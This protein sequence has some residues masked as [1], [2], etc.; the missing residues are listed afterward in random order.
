[1]LARERRDDGAVTRNG[2]GVRG[3]GLAACA[4][5]VAACAAQSVAPEAT[6]V[7]E[8]ARKDAAAF[9]RGTV[10]DVYRSLRRGRLDSSQSLLADEAFVVGP[11]AVDVYTG[12]TDAVLA[13][14]NAFAAGD[15]HKLRS[16]GLVAEAS[17]TGQSAWVLDRIEI[18]RRPYTVVAVLAQV[19]DIWYVVAVHLAAAKPSAVEGELP[20]LAGGVGAGAEPVVEL[21]RAAVGGPD[22]VIEQLSDHARATAFGPGHKDHLR[23]K[24]KIART[25]KRKRR[26]PAPL[27]VTGN[28]RA[29]V[30]PDGGLAWVVANT[31]PADDKAGA[32]RRAMLVYERVEDQWRLVAM[33]T[34][35]AFR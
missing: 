34:A 4:L 30:T 24:R 21:A 9:A 19:D 14:T 7:A 17:V 13:V 32:P 28:V 6:P 5:V 18:D 33:Q 25:W 1:M 10:A 26:A 16:R 27:R 35:A 22:A 11:R 15:R 29:G 31:R 12:R 8:G 3:V 2:L 23:G 20:P